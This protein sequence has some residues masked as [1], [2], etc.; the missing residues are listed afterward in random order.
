VVTE[1]APGE[2]VVQ[3]AIAIA[4][5]LSQKTEVT[6]RHTRQLLTRRFS[7]IIAE[8]MAHGWPLAAMS[9]LRKAQP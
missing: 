3:R 2:Q 8:G 1:T 9:A 6:Q 4:E 5:D 7:Q